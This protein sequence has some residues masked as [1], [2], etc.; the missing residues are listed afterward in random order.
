MLRCYRKP[1]HF[2][3]SPPFQRKLIL[4]VAMFQPVG[5]GDCLEVAIA[6]AAIQLEI[7]AI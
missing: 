4:Q 7:E 5:S 3:P 1:Y 6:K 2:Y